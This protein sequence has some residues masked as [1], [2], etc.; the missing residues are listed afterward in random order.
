MHDH[1][2]PAFRW[3]VLFVVFFATV[4][5]GVVLIWPAPLME[6]I[7]RH[8]GL[9]LGA[10]TGTIMLA[11][12]I[13]VT[14]GAVI[15]GICCDRFGWVRTLLVTISLL[16][17]ATLMV[18]FCS[19]SLGALL[20]ARAI[21]GLGAGPTMAAIGGV[22]VQW[23]PR[24]ERG[25]PLGMQGMGL[26]LGVALGFVFVP[27]A[28]VH[29]GS[30]LHAAAWM[31]AFPILGILLL[32][33]VALGVR[34]PTAGSDP[35]ESEPANSDHDF[36]QATRLPVFYVGLAC[37]FLECWVMQAFNDLTPVYLSAAAPLG[38]G[39]GLVLAGKF[40]GIVQLSIMMGSVASGFILSWLFRGRNKGVVGLG[41][42]AAAIFA[43]SVRFPFITG[44]LRALPVCLFCVGFFQGLI[45]PSTLAFIST[46][47]P[48]HI[49]G[50]LTGLWMGL[51]ILGG[52]V[53]ILV[54][55]ALL[56]ATGGYHASILT[57]GVVA[58]AGWLCSLLL[59]PPQVFRAFAK[60]PGILEPDNS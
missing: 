26:S 50:K 2:Y 3:F 8:Y 18:P 16:A 55:S 24:R 28:Y 37:V 52:T 56:H 4:S 34:P 12:N 33:A 43:L 19:R 31:S 44:N 38:A 9:D 10:A 15:G 45:I 22:A 39:H 60:S 54:G 58:F 27:M 49:V 20:A 7:A 6:Q 23:F 57:V 41:F 48:S 13:F 51:G 53:G 30:F 32:L 29:T 40:M 11:F 1:A 46:N 36:R 21:A 17:L 59:T 35:A 25:I 14:V 5:Q 42:L 47:F